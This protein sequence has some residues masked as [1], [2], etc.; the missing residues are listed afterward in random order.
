M[1]LITRTAPAVLN[2][3]EA[4]FFK[5][6]SKISQL[7]GDETWGQVRRTS[8][9]LASQS[10]TCKLFGSCGARR[11]AEKSQLPQAGGP[12]RRENLVRL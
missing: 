4:D 3:S 7:W 5:F 6:E 12:R 11:I 8:E 9:R 10:S 1:S 2:G